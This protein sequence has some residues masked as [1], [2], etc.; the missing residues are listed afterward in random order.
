M[1]SRAI[2]KYRC[3]CQQCIDVNFES[4]VNFIS[5]NEEASLHFKTQHLDVQVENCF[6][7]ISMTQVFVNQ[8]DK[9]IEGEYMFPIETTLKNTAVS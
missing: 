5:K 4:E 3:P 8:T 6:A 1:Q 2:R 9:L 7:V